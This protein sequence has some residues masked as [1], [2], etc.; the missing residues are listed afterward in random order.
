LDVASVRVAPTRSKSE[1]ELWLEGPGK[2]QRQKSFLVEVLSFFHFRTMH[3]KG[4][5]RKEEVLTWEIIRAWQLLPS[6]L[7]L[8]R[9][10]RRLLITGGT[11]KDSKVMSA[12]QP[13]LDA[14]AAEGD[15]SVK[16][17]PSTRLDGS[18]AGACGDISIGLG[19]SAANDSERIWFE[20]KTARV[21]KPGNL[22]KQV[23]GQKEALQRKEPSL[24]VAVIELLP[25]GVETEL[26][27][28][29]WG[30]VRDDLALGLEDLQESRSA[31]S[32]TG[33]QRLAME[34][35]RRIESHPNNLCGESA[36][37]DARPT[38]TAA[39]DSSRGSAGRSARSQAAR[40][41]S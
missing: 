5:W 13:L 36:T 25:C 32:L 37:R 6:T 2:D 19:T 15:V 31:V 18:K 34:L 14:I 38:G 3:L 7:F 33:Y 26:P 41:G 11:F 1:V 24:P 20:A 28:I 27:A 16:G 8:A 9:T 22:L 21:S 23:H 35:V 30:D 29:T 4:S 39:R 10:L 40:S 17:E 12:V